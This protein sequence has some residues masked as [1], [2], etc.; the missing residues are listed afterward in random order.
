MDKEGRVKLSHNS[1]FYM[2]WAR[3]ILFDEMESRSFVVKFANSLFRFGDAFKQF[4]Y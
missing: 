3:Y 4:C 2:P 1:P